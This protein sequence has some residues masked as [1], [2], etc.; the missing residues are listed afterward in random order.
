MAVRTADAGRRP[1]SGAR[2]FD[3]GDP[4]AWKNDPIL[5]RAAVGD[6]IPGDGS[7]DPLNPDAGLR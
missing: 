3:A 5:R 7:W 4:A 6:S 2:W 1:D